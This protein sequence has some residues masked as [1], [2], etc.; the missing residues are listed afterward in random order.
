LAIYRRLFRAVFERFVTKKPMAVRARAV[1]ENALAPSDLEA[2]F[3]TEAN[4]GDER[5][6]LFSSMVDVMT[7]VVTRVPP[8]RKAA[9]EEVHDTLPAARTA[10][11]EKV[12]HVEPHVTRA[13]VRHAAARTGARIDAMGGALEPLLPGDDVRIVEGNPLAATERRRKVLRGSS[14]GPL[15]GFGLV[16][17]D[18]QR[19][20]RLD[21]LPC[22]DGPAQERSLLP[23]LL[24]SSGGA[25]G[26]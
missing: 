22:E 20:L 10:V 3:R 15:P 5:K 12:A 11:D 26:T 25:S 13:L 2:L 4:V 9:F 18:P 19:T 17:L 23:E 14:A 6:L 1:F 16:V 21:V 7:V 24:P 8:S